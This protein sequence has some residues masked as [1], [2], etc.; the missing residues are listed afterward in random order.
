MIRSMG[1]HDARVAVAVA[2]VASWAL[3]LVVRR[4]FRRTGT[5]LQI[6]AATLARLVATGVLGWIAIRLVERG[7]LWLLLAFVFGLL[8]LAGLA[9]S[10]LLVV[11]LFMR[12]ED[13]S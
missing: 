7:G 1:W 3:G 10:A 13:A 5:T 4:P 12:G 8:A 6:A 11:A 2:I 9:F